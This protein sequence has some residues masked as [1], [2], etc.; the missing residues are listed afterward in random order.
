MKNKVSHQA[1]AMRF[2]I[3]SCKGS[4]QTVKAYCREQGLAPSKFYYWQ[5]RLQTTDVYAG[6]TQIPSPAADT[7][8]VTMQFPNGIH[9]SFTGRVSTAVLKELVCCI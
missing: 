6:F 4:T 1:E 9:I 8:T 5:K 3:E 7:T 2:H